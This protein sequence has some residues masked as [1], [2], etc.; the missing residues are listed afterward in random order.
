MFKI[1]NEKIKYYVNSFEY[2]RITLQFC[3]NDSK[4]VEVNFPPK[5]F[6]PG[7]KLPFAIFLYSC[8]YMTILVL[9]FDYKF[10]RTNP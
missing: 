3:N 5:Y 9:F 4:R 2:D 8:K 6:V 10:L 1:Y 7:D